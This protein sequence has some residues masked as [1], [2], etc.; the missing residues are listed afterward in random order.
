MDSLQNLSVPIVLGRRVSKEK[1][2]QHLMDIFCLK[3]SDT[4]IVNE[5]VKTKILNEFKLTNVDQ[6]KRNGKKIFQ[7]RTHVFDISID[8]KQL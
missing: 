7:N 2:E 5:L 4:K 1:K 3:I 6:T 8:I